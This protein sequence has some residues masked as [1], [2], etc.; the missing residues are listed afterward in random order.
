MTK[1]QTMQAAIA[2]HIEDGSSIFMGCALE[3]LIY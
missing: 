2:E 3:S 1:L